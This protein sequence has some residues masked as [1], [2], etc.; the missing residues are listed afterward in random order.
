MKIAVPLTNE[1]QISNHFGESDFFGVFTISENNEITDIHTLESPDGCGCKSDIA[2]Q[3]A[4]DG[5]SIFIAAGM[6]GGAAS[7]FTRSGISVVRGRSGDAA[8]VVMEYLSGDVEDLGSSCHRHGETLV[9]APKQLHVHH[10][11]DH[12][13][14]DHHHDSAHSCGCGTEG[15]SCGCN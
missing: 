7:K 12:H 9:H 8:E 3:L 5:V 14:H 11:H 10:H 4:T 15:H 2:D 13:H 6:G 1:N